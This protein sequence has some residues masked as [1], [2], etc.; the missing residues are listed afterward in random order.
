MT[1]AQVAVAAASRLALVV[2]L[3]G[4]VW[5]G[6]IR[7]CWAFAAYVVAVLLGNMLVSLWPEHF[8]TPEF[9][10]VKH[11]AYDVL[12]VAIALELAWRAFRAFPGAL[13]V[14]RVVLLVL[15]TAST[16]CLALFNPRSSYETVWEWQPG[17]AT[18]AIWLLA[19]TALMV[20]WYQVPVS[21]WQRAIM[22][23][24]ALYLLVFVTLLGLLA[25]WGWVLGPVVSMTETLVYLALVTLWAWAA[26]RREAAGAAAVPAAS[27]A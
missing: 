18:A 3:A 2:L 11:G 21:G 23:G 8:Y 22:L 1:E 16:V 19:A 15:L 9:W 5:R 6:R 27:P 12:K 24:L 13:R 20:V 14:V 4:M 17:F 26:W 10:V 25:R 7:E